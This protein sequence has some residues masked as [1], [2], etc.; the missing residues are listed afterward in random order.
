MH[1]DEGAILDLAGMQQRHVADS[2]VPADVVIRPRAA[3]WTTV[4]SCRLEFSPTRM[5]GPSPRRMQPNQMLRWP[6]LDLAHQR[7]RWAR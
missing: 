4:P 2:D 7:R 3:T 1:A 5:P 6:D